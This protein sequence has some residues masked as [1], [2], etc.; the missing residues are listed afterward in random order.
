MRKPPQWAYTG[1]IMTDE[2]TPPRDD[3]DPRERDLARRGRAPGGN[4]WMIVILIVLLGAA[5]YT[6]SALL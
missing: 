4:P 1:R 3:E 2:R 6:A 5:V